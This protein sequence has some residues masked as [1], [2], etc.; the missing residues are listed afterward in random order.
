M[1]NKVK[2]AT[3]DFSSQ[4]FKW[5][6]WYLPIMV[7]IYILVSIFLSDPEIDGMSF[8]AMSLSANEIFML[9]SGILSVFMF[10][11]LSI[12]LGLTRRTFLRSMLLTGGIITIALAVIT[13]II[14]VIMGL[15]PWFG[16]GLVMGPLESSPVAHVIGHLLTTFTFFLG[17]FI[18][19][20]GFYRGFLGGMISIVL[21]LCILVA[22]DSLW[23]WQTRGTVFDMD[24]TQYASGNL[25]MTIIF[26]LFLIFFT[27]AILQS[28][29]RS[30]PV[31]VK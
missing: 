4:I 23:M 3:M 13:G 20:I 8:Y 10:L 2:L 27:I 29:V 17:G 9:V 14:S 15:M 26:S 5:T 30:V 16:T 24:V 18:I 31:K 22:I 21:S 28:L 7:I 25:F 11:E 19:S 6:L 1:N 12:S